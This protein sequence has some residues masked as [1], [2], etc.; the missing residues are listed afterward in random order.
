MATRSRTDDGV[1]DDAVAIRP[2]PE[3]QLYFEAF[4]DFRVEGSDPDDV[5][6]KALLV[7]RQH[8][9][10]WLFTE[11]GLSIEVREGHQSARFFG[12]AHLVRSVE[13]SYEDEPALDT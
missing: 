7:H 13:F 6:V 12:T 5:I 11:Q 8:Y 4:L 9:S 2:D 10:N 1:G 3:P